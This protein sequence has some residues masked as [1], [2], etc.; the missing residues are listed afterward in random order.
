V[1]ELGERFGRRQPPGLEAQLSN[2]ADEIAYNNHDV[3]DGVR[4]GLLTVEDLAEVALF[5][6][7]YR[8]MARKRPRTGRR[9]LVHEAVRRMVDYI[10]TDLI[11]TTARRIARHQPRDIDAV[12]A[13][14]GPIVGLSRE[15][16][17]GHLELKRF[18][19]QRL[20]RHPRV[21]G[22]T[23]RAREV[24][25]GLFACYLEDPA[26]L[27]REH[28]GIA[29]RL[30]KAEGRAGRARAVADYV[31]GMTDRYAISAYRRLVEPTLDW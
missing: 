22:M 15:A 19:G 28:A 18:L 31:A 24:V 13:L 21:L 29:A 11:D 17:T 23:R 26:R 2:I 14:P 16:A 8:P 7:F 12:R 20:Y 1:G 4:S 9:V 6:E 30:E 25:A 3:D 10:V 5:A 27:P